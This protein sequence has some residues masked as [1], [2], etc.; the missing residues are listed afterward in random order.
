MWMNMQSQ[1]DLQLAEAE[2]AERIDAEVQP[3]RKSA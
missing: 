1:Y 2:L 3:Y